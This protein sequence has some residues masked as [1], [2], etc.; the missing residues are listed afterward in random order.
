M[1]VLRSPQKR[2][3]KT[4]LF[5]KAGLSQESLIY[6]WRIIYIIFTVLFDYFVQLLLNISSQSTDNHEEIH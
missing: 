3:R 5:H 1:T 6:L 4:F 2:H